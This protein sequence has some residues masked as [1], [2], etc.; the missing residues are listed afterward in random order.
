MFKGSGIETRSHKGC[1][2]ESFK[3]SEKIKTINNQQNIQKNLKRE[4]FLQ[5]YIL[6]P[7]RI[8]CLMDHRSNE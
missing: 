2:I 3:Y 8:D 4:V 5:N 7:S 6:N 1:V